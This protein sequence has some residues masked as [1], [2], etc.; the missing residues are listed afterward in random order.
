ML[1]TGS[2]KYQLY[3]QGD[4]TWRLNTD[5]GWACVLFATDA[6]W[7]KARVYQQGCRAFSAASEL[8]GY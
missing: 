5:T 8:K 2:G 1:F 3:R 6:Q 7:R 4:I